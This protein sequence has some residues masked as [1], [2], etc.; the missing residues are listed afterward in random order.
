MN[1]A[2]Y[3]LFLL[4]HSALP[5][6]LLIWAA[7]Q[8]RKGG[9]IRQWH[10]ALGLGRRESPARKALDLGPRPGQA[11]P[12]QERQHT[13]EDFWEEKKKNPRAGNHEIR[14]SLC[15]CHQPARQFR[16]VTVHALV[17]SPEK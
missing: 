6:Q 4:L 12:G 11:R 3:S 1:S 9:T 7:V 10:P 5:P 2:A 17:S 8:R 13:G 16:Q 15:S 14:F